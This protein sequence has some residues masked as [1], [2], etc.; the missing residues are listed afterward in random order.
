MRILKNIDID[1][2]ENGMII[3][4]AQA[5]GYEYNMPVMERNKYLKRDM[6]EEDE[7]KFWKE[8]EKIRDKYDI[9]FREYMDDIFDW[10]KEN[11]YLEVDDDS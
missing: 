3:A 5:M 2:L 9:I 8:Q 10:L 7:I 6:T 11:N 1:E 4:I